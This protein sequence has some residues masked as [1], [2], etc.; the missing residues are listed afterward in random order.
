M[1]INPFGPTR[2]VCYGEV[3]AIRGGCY[4]SYRFF[5]IRVTDLTSQINKQ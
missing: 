4:K 3:S 5:C 2:A 1:N